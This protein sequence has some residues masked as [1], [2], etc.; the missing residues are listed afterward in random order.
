MSLDTKNSR[1]K[2]GGEMLLVDID[3]DFDLDTVYVERDSHGNLPVVNSGANVKCVEKNMVMES[4]EDRIKNAKKEYEEEKKQ[5]E[6]M[7]KEIDR[8]SQERWYNREFR[9]LE[10]GARKM[11]SLLIR[12]LAFYMRAESNDNF[13]ATKL[14]KMLTIQGRAG[15]IKVTV[16]SRLNFMF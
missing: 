1:E 10:T 15:N 12:R 14:K 7:R 9:R 13:I 8:C 11:N 6:T 5:R 16:L 4:L 2:T 3:G